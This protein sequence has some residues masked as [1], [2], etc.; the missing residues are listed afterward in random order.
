MLT[1]LGNSWKVRG[2]VAIQHVGGSSREMY[3][4][5]ELRFLSLSLTF[6]QKVQCNIATKILPSPSTLSYPMHS[7]LCFSEIFKIIF[8]RRWG[9]QKSPKRQ[10]SAF[11]E[12]LYCLFSLAKFHKDIII[13]EVGLGIVYWGIINDVALFVAIKRWRST[14]IAGHESR[15]EAQMLCHLHHPNILSLIGFCEENGEVI[16]AYEYVSNG[17]V[18]DH[19]HRKSC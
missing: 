7:C 15:C 3:M 12:E 6:V 13:C 9:K 14:W 10:N 5:I 17:T 4:T 8:K 18:S 19:L 1:K 16:R 11:P 2:R